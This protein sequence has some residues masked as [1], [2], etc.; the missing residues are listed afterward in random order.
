M[1]GTT[2]KPL[3]K[4]PLPKPAVSAKASQPET[5][6]K[7]NHY[8][9]YGSMILLFLVSV[10]VFSPMTKNGFIDTWDDGVYILKNKLLHDLSGEGI[11]NMFR[12]G[13]DFQKLVNNYH[14]LTILTL[15]INYKISGL[16][17][18][19]YHAPTMALHGLNAVL[20]FIFVYLL[21]RRKLWPALVS[22][23]LFAVHPMHVE[24]VAW[25]T[26]RKDVL[27][28]F[29]F[30]GGLIAYVKYLEDE[31][32]WK[33]GIVLLLFLL[34]CLS[35]A[36]AAL[37]AEMGNRE[38]GFGEKAGEA[39]RM[40]WG[41]LGGKK[42]L[43]NAA[44]SV[45]FDDQNQNK[46]FAAEK[47]KESG[48]LFKKA[49]DTENP[50]VSDKP[51]IY[52]PDYLSSLDKTKSNI[53]QKSTNVGAVNTTINIHTTTLEKSKGKIKEEIQSILLSAVSDT[54]YAK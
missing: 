1:A 15:A 21:T 8:L 31:K 47:R 32:I 39:A 34:S 49:Y 22:G 30:L 35:K 51:L 53:N 23:L 17:P 20:V 13:D 12:F 26:E 5:L 43:A 25:A 14:P 27:Y 3:N 10:I 36:M 29:F 9:V 33:L 2:K 4:K 42:G 44:A 40:A 19:S 38:K 18:T 54:Q 45:A 46:Q 48:L 24:S 37:D 11:A 6:N 52:S 50:T 41:F 28:T 16:N 7:T